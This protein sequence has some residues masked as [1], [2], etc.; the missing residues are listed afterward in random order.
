MTDRV[1]A[2]VRELQNAVGTRLLYPSGHPRL[3][4]SVDRVLRLLAGLT[5]NLPDISVYVLDNRLI[6]EGTPLPSVEVVARGMFATLRACGFDRLTLG[7]RVSAQELEAFLSSLSQ[8]VREGDRPSTAPS[9]SPNLRLSSLQS[10]AV[11]ASQPRAAHFAGEVSAL[12]GLWAGI[13]GDRKLELDT[14][15]GIVLVLSKTVEENLGAIL[16]T[17]ALRSHDEYTATHIMNVAL[18]AMALA[19]ALGLPE[20]VVHEVGV[21]ALLHD[22]GK[23]RVPEEIL[24][25]PDRLTD[26]QVTLMRRHPE[27]GARILLA[28]PGTPDLA[29]AVAFEHHIRFDGGGYPSVPQG[30]RISLASAITEVADIYDALRSDRPYRQ[31]HPHAAIERMMTADSGSVFDPELLD[32]FF[33][34]V[35]RE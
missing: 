15:E 18:L 8:A 30:W 16:P 24:T 2:L 22:V 9:S 1:A 26:E 23:L 13:L 34:V 17:A 3:R 5:D 32:V 33:D 19:E 28:T 21:A 14:L 7:R 6:Y 11:A 27:D 35:V 10:L 4:A 29:S 20:R 12:R 25:K 31:G